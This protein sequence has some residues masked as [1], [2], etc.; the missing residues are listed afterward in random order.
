TSRVPFDPESPS[1]MALLEEQAL[2]ALRLH[3]VNEFAVEGLAQPAQLLVIEPP[4]VHANRDPVQLLRQPPA[5]TLNQPRGLAAAPTRSDQRLG[6]AG[7]TDARE[8]P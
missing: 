1:L 6:G 4:H 2:D 5:G 7:A 8:H 3:T